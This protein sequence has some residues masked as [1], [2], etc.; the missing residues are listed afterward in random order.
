[1]I[2]SE[3]FNEKLQKLAIQYE[4]ALKRLKVAKNN[5]EIES[6]KL[7][8]LQ[9]QCEHFEAELDEI[10]RNRLENNDALIKLHK[11]IMEQNSKVERA[12]RELKT[13]KKA[14]A[15]KVGDKEYVRLL[16]VSF[17]EEDL[18]CPFSFV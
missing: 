10:T 1:M 12:K 4:T 8:E 6:T 11:E 5:F 2:F 17:C 3:E 14:M 7:D 13:A 15:K 16:E 18:L 9:R